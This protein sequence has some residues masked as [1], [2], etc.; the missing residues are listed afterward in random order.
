MKGF[1]I[2]LMTSQERELRYELYNRY[3]VMTVAQLSAIELSS[4]TELEREY[5]AMALASRVK[6]ES[7]LKSGRW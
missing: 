7:D 3:M 5:V 2:R 6:A 1:T 4:L